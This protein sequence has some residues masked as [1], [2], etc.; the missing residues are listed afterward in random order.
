MS[1]VVAAK[2]ASA[3]PRRNFLGWVSASLPITLAA[4]NDEPIV[5]VAD[6]RPPG[7]IDYG[8]LVL[9]YFG[10]AGRGDAEAIGNYYAQFSKLSSSEAFE[11]TA[12]TRAFI[13]ANAD[14][15]EA[16]AALDELVRE[17]F[18]ELRLT[19]V[20]GWTLSSAEVDL[21]VLAWLA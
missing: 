17:D 13:D 20:G 15:P 18:L 21:C 5:F 6:D 7:S 3:L 10:E 19:D 2:D 8:E 4:C 11:A 14:I 1:R 12:E 9:Q 16:L